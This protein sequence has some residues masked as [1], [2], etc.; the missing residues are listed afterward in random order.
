MA[1]E[2]KR[3]SRNTV[4]GSTALGLAGIFITV[5]LHS[6]DVHF[7]NIRGGDDEIR[8]RSDLPPR[9]VVRLKIVVLQRRNPGGEIRRAVSD[10]TRSAVVDAGGPVHHLVGREAHFLRTRASPWATEGV[11]RERER[12]ENG[13]FPQRM[14]RCKWRKR[15]RIWQR[16]IVRNAECREILGFLVSLQLKP[17]GGRAMAGK[18]TG[19]HNP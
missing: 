7:E 2:F 4:H 6:H 13:R 5:F 17:F 15:G 19:N 10:E 16:W 8:D 3:S 11:E 1:H 14:A 12:E 18:G 9:Q